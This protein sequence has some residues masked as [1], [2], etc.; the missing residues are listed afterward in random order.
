MFP[1]NLASKDGGT[2]LIKKVDLV[3]WAKNGATMLTKVLERIDE[4]IPR[5]VIGKKV[6]VDDSSVDN[7]SSIAKNF[8]WLVFTNE[9]GGIG[10]G[11]NLAL[12]QVTNE[13]FI[14]LEQ[15]VVLAGDW[16]E[17]IPKY[18]MEKDVAVA[19]GWRIS[20]HSVI[21]KIDEYSMER[22]RGSLCSIDNTIYKTKIIKALGGFPEHLRYTGVDAHIHQ[23]VLN[24]GFKWVTDCTI[25]SVHLRKGGLREQIKRYYLYGID[26]PILAKEELFIGAGATSGLRRSASIALFSPFRGLEIAIKKRCPQAVYYYPFIRFSHLKGALKKAKS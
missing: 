14:S 20:D 13:H 25:L 16:W 5:E 21:G 15:D 26:M 12:R 2:R 3:M 23:S 11:A 6:F 24:A 7:S 22:F 17:K 4:V 8:G 18:L 1:R 19:Q 10:A 9:K